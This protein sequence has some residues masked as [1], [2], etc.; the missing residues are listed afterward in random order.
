M[1]NKSLVL[2]MMRTLVISLV[3][4]IPLQKDV[5]NLLV[6]VIKESKQQEHSTQNGKTH[7]AT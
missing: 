3:V 4:V 7:Q 6:E 5:I 1:K 2:S